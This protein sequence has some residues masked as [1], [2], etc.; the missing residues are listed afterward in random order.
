MTKSMAGKVLCGLVLA[1]FLCAGCGNSEGAASTRV[2]LTTGFDKDEVFRIDSES[3]RIP[4]ILVYLT[5]TQNQYE[6]VYGP[7]IWETDLRG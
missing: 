3:C 7:Q 6:Q 4:E 5:N 2:V 1:V